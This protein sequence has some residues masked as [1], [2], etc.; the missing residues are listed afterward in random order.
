MESHAVDIFLRYQAIATHM[1]NIL[2]R[3]DIILPEPHWCRAPDVTIISLNDIAYYLV[4]HGLY[5]LGFSYPFLIYVQS[6][7]CSNQ[8]FTP[9]CSAERITLDVRQLLQ[10]PL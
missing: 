7:V 2:I 1:T 4:A 3:L 10:P 8:D 5:W 9:A 6:F